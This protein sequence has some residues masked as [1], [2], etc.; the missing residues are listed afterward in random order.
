MKRILAISWSLPPLLGARSLQVARSLDTLASCGWDVH[1]ISV[2]PGSLFPGSQLDKALSL[3]Y[4]GKIQVVR[5]AAPISYWLLTVLRRFF[6]SWMP[7]P[8]IHIGWAKR[9][10]KR[11]ESIFADHQ[12]D[13]LITFGRP[14]SDHIA[15]QTLRTRMDIPWLAHFSD[16]WADNPYDASQSRAQK[17]KSLRMEKA[18]VQEASAVV[19]TSQDTLDLVMAKYPTE[20]RAKAHVVSHG[21]DRSVLPEVEEPVT[22]QHERL[23]LVHTGNFYGLRTPESVLEAVNILKRQ[24]EDGRLIQI[25]F[26]GN[27]K[28]LDKWQ[29]YVD[30]HGLAQQVRFLPSVAYRESLY[31]AAGADVLMVIDASSESESVFLPSKLVDYL[32]FT[33]PILGITPDLGASAK[34]L[35]R[36]RQPTTAPDDP[37]AIAQALQELVKKW[38]RGS[39]GVSSNFDQIAKDYDIDNTTDRLEKILLN[40]I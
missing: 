11:A 23:R 5:V 35:R 39:L 13:A 24:S 22:T 12:F 16:P 8:D 25:S 3:Q 37:K 14:F 32:M 18:V 29:A 4:L 31:A 38:K 2:E 28:H 34:L 30:T 7:S 17:A 20:W 26:I 33:K 10:A 6:L 15:G 36:L 19:F 27:T 1:A 40:L 21:F 9:V